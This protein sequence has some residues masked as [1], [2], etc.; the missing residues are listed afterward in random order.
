MIEGTHIPYR[1]D[2]HEAD[3]MQWIGILFHA[4]KGCEECIDKVKEL[5]PQD[6]DRLPRHWKA[7]D[8]EV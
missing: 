1:V 4:Q 8:V 6:Y 2:A 7:E 3:M 5:S